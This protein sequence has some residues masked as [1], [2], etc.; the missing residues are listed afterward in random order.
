MGW[1][2]GFEPTISRA[3][4]WRLDHLATPTMTD[5]ILAS[6]AIG[7]QTEVR[8]KGQGSRN[9][10]SSPLPVGAGARHPSPLSRGTGGKAPLRRA[11]PLQAGDGGG[12]GG[13]VIGGAAVLLLGGDDPQEVAD[14]DGIA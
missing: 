13:D 14:R 5:L 3:T 4:T 7:G 2:M 10:A 12:F 6:E 11:G 8:V 9:K 1:A